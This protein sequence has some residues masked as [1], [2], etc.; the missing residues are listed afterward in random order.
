LAIKNEIDTGF[1]ARAKNEIALEKVKMTLATDWMFEGRSENS[2]RA[3]Q[4]LKYYHNA[5]EIEKQKGFPER[6]KLLSHNYENYASSAF[7]DIDDA[8]NT[9]LFSD[10]TISDFRNVQDLTEQKKAENFSADDVFMWP[11]LRVRIAIKEFASFIK[12]I[13]VNRK[14][15]EV[16]SMPLGVNEA[17]IAEMSV[18][19]QSILG[20]KL[21]KCADGDI[22]EP[23]IIKEIR[24]FSNRL[25]FKNEVEEIDF[26]PS[27]VVLPMRAMLRAVFK[28]GTAAS[29]YSRI[30]INYSGTKY[31]FPAMGKTGTTNENRTVAFCGSVPLDTLITMCSYVG[32]DDNTQLK[33]KSFSIA[34]S[35]GA[36]PQWAALA[37]AAISQNKSE[38]ILNEPIDYINTIATGEVPLPNMPSFIEV[39]RKGGLP[40]K[41]DTLETTTTTRPAL[42]PNF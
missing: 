30:S 12:S 15:Q 31:P 4:A 34:G 13:G 23:C 26:L 1:T 2:I 7:I 18:A 6:I 25:L 17:T 14:L 28:Y 11:E 42:F 5:S 9:E 8:E 32:F 29:A 20:G 35:S 37:E 16:I 40:T 27:S 41:P 3:L 19:Y 10:F 22:A 39:D 21:Y 38:K 36:L 33:S 24:D